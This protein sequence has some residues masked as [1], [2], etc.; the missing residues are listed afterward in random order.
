[1]IFPLKSVF[2]FLMLERTRLLEL[3]TMRASRLSINPLTRW[4][5]LRSK[6]RAPLCITTPLKSKKTSN[7]GFSDDTYFQSI[8]PDKLA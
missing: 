2:S 8:E 5:Q 3:M 4:T 1:M 6:R 7:F